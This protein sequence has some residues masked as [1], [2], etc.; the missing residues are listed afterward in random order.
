MFEEVLG[1]S[2]HCFFEEVEGKLVFL[3]ELFVFFFQFVHD[4]LSF[5]LEIFLR[6]DHAL[7][8]G[9]VVPNDHL[10]YYPLRLVGRE[11]QLQDL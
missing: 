8:V 7:A 5:Q 6:L 4:R 3:V 10:V 9:T 2:Q 11:L 1:G